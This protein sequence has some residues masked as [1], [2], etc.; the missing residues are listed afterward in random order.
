MR[1]AVGLILA[2]VVSVVV[3]AAV[4][5]WTYSRVVLAA[6][7]TVSALISVAVKAPVCVVVKLPTVVALR[8]AICVAEPVTTS[9]DG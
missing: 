2:S 3:I 7:A 4:W 5:F 6:P 9:R 1:N 8:P